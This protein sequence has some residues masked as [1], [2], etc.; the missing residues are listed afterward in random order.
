MLYILY[1]HSMVN[2]YPKHFAGTAFHQIV[3]CSSYLICLWKAK[4]RGGRPGSA[5]SEVQPNLSEE[6]RAGCRGMLEVIA[7]LQAAMTMLQLGLAGLVVFC[8]GPAEDPAA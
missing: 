6:I 2:V 4:L 3:L 8:S 5:L 7:V 1:V